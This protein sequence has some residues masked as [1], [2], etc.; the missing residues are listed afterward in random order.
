MVLVGKRSEDSPMKSTPTH[1]PRATGL[2]TPRTSERAWPSLTS[3]QRGIPDPLATPTKKGGSLTQQPSSSSKGLFTDDDDSFGWDEDLEEQVGK[4]TQQEPVPTPRLPPPET[5][6]KVPRTD[7]L[8]SPGKRKLADMEGDGEGGYSSIK[9]E[10][11]GSSFPYTP[12][13]S[14]APPRQPDFSSL[15]TPQTDSLETTSSVGQA[16]PT[17]ARFSSQ[18]PFTQGNSAQNSSYPQTSPSKSS[19]S[20]CPLAKQSLTL[21]DAHKISLTQPAKDDL[22][23]LLDRNDLKMQ[24]ISRGRDITRVALQKK[25]ENNKELMSER[26][27][28]RAALQKEEEKNRELMGRIEALETQRELDKATIS[29]LMMERRK[30][31]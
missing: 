2:P 6:R 26:D 12:S 28:A 30:N 27:T 4:L 29:G 23:S 8:T 17:P 7:T 20:P 3:G 19:S 25:E 1:T 13:T 5:P 9:T 24:G 10:G 21:L 11:S 18:D 22:L 31:G 16:T 14:T 15:Y